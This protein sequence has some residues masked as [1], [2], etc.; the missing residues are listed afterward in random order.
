VVSLIN[1]GL[2]LSG[3]QNIHLAW[4]LW[5]IAAMLLLLAL[6]HD[7]HVWHI[8]RRLA[9]QMGIEPIHVIIL[10]LAVAACGVAWS[11]YQ[12]AF[13][14]TRIG[15]PTAV[16]ADA[17][18]AIPSQATPIPRTQPYRLTDNGRSADKQS[19]VRVSDGAVIPPDPRNSDAYVYFQWLAAGNKP[20]PAQ[21]T[22]PS[23]YAPRSPSDADR[24]IKMVDKLS[25]LLE[26]QVR[27][28]LSE[29]GSGWSNWQDAL[30]SDKSGD[31]FK[32]LSNFRQQFVSINATILDSTKEMPQFCD[33][34]LCE[35]V[36]LQR[37][38]T[39]VVDAVDKFH[40]I[41]SILHDVIDAEK[42]RQFKNVGTVSQIIAPHQQRIGSPL[43]SYEVELS[44]AEQRLK[45]RR[46]ELSEIASR[47]R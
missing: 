44:W 37:T 20:D 5:C 46:R 29:A 9:G 12:G 41:L 32:G 3:Y 38:A 47:P 27:P 16:T 40:E 6:Y 7:V 24:E 15:A 13:S 43:T 17:K 30:D 39:A 4:A 31:Y 23:V 21:A 25:D 18:A 34:D 28:L 42:Y 22:L 33:D 10:G 36:N 14:T 35:I 45:E 1:V 8:K 26:R 11:L 19:I 2:Q